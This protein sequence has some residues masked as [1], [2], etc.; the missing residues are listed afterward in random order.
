MLVLTELVERPLLSESGRVRDSE[1]RCENFKA[2][3]APKPRNI[4]TEIA[5]IASKQVVIAQ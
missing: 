1:E 5:K 3:E 2:L 4:R